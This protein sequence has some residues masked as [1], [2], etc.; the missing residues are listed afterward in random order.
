MN[1]GIFRMY[2]VRGIAEED[3]TDDIVYKIGRAFAAYI[4]RRGGKK[5]VSGMDVR[6]SSPRIKDAFV[7]GV[8]NSGIDVIDTGICTTPM[9]YYSQHFHN[10]DGGIMVTGSHNPIEYNGLKMVDPDVTIYGDVIQQFYELAENEDFEGGS[11]EYSEYD[12]ENDYIDMCVSA[13]NIGG[14]LKVLVDPGNGTAGPVAGKIFE[15]LGVEADFINKERDGTFPN[16]LP[17]PTVME[18][19]EELVEKTASGDY[20]MGIGYDGDCDRIGLLDE[21]GDVIY[22]DQILGI[23]AY[24]LLS[25]RKGE[26]IV[27]DVKCSQGLE[28]MINNMGGKPIMYKTGHSLLKRKMKEENALLAGEMSGHMFF[29]E[30]FYGFDDGLFASLLIMQ[31]VSQ[32]KR[33][34]SDLKGV[35]PYYHSTPEIRVDCTD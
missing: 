30:N 25:R 9:L 32:S 20:D 5:V 3:L 35:M 10:A 19:I 26:K 1:R 27:F 16:H 21:N 8:L 29:N 6:L 17:D 23:L 4:K 14:S 34:L 2:D 12:I 7:R 18:Y 24:D 13:V 31:I 22:G 11:G 15:K 28:E 33:K